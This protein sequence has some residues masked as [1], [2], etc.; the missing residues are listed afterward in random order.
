[1]PKT[2]L[3]PVEV[4]A[5]HGWAGD[6]SG[7]APWQTATAPLGWRWRCGERGYGGL[8]PVIPHW[9]A[10][11]TRV[12]IGHSLGPHLLPAGLL[13]A[14]ELVVL[15]AGFGRFLPPG[16]QA[17]RLRS[18]LEGMAARL[19][20]GPTE[21][22]AAERTQALLRSFLAEAAQPDPE[23]LLPP[24]PADHPVAAVG[25]ERLR[26]DLQLLERSTGLPTGF[27]EAA[28][29]LIVEAA[30]DRIVVPAARLL[31]REALPGAT[32]L[33]LPGAGHCLLRAEVIPTVLSWIQQ[34]LPQGR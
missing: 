25:R 30:A 15:L 5:M 2:D 17:R 14:A 28:K 24:G 18:A 6:G 12:V 32:V 1:M 22:E 3:P 10:A 11:G 19:Q 23:A 8:P 31:L 34:Q 13:A 33:T 4:I 26:R 27:P 16:R 29:V 7:W 9:G 21:A 20:E